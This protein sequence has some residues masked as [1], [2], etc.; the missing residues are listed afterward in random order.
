[1]PQIKITDSQG[2]VQSTGAGVI[3][4]SKGLLCTTQEDKTIAVTVDTDYNGSITLPAGAMI[5]DVAIICTDS[6]QT[7]NTSNDDEIEFR[8]GTNSNGS[9]QEIIALTEIVERHKVIPV[10]AVTSVKNASL[11]LAGCVAPAFVAGAPLYSS[12]ARTI[13]YRYRVDN[14][15]LV[16]A[17]ALKLVLTYSVI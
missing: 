3:V 10:G 16:A 1:M 6:L 13:Y 8:M 17:G 11:L 2:L 14:T 15:A 12:T 4:E 5:E 7:A 9:G